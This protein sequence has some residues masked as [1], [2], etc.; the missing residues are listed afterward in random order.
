M[1][2]EH[3]KWE[4][5][6]VRPLASNSINAKMDRNC[7]PSANQVVSSTESRCNHA[8]C[9]LQVHHPPPPVLPL[10]LKQYLSQN[11]IA[12]SDIMELIVS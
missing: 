3:G 9:T 7:P 12:R 6:Q 4:T 2:L 8:V 10:V 11:Y 1:G 5:L